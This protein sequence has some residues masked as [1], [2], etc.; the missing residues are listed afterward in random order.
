MVDRVTPR[1]GVE[2]VFDLGEHWAL[3]ARAGYVYEPTGLSAGSTPS[4]VDADRQVFSLGGGL[5]WE[6]PSL[7]F[8]GKLDLS[9]HAQWGMLSEQQF[10]DPFDHEQRTANGS[11]LGAG[12]TLSY[13]FE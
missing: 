4:L 5:S 9:A 12:A 13:A 3:R 8:P 11:F 7:A 1:I 2:Y 10:T 6:R